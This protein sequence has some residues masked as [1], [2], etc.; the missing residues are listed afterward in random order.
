MK[1]GENA[2]KREKMGRPLDRDRNASYN[3]SD[4]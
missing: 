4:N 3:V 2:E 1:V